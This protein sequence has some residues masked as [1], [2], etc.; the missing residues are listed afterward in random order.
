MTTNDN[1]YDEP[2]T[3][4]PV[5]WR[6]FPIIGANYDFQPH[7]QEVAM[8]TNQQRKLALAVADI[9]ATDPQATV[10]RVARKLGRT[11]WEIRVACYRA[12]IPLKVGRP[13]RK[14]N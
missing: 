6:D 2:F 7:W 11:R 14:G 8:T 10:G 12:G 9:F 13:R 5:D 4:F 1:E 3:V